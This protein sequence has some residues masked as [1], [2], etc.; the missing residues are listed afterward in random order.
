M[1]I[2]EIK[3][4]AMANPD[5]EYW[6]PVNVGFPNLAPWYM[7]SSHGNLKSVAWK[8]I[9]SNGRWMMIKPKVIKQLPNKYGYKTYLY[10]NGQV[11]KEYKRV[12]ETTH[13][14]VLLCFNPDAQNNLTVN[15]INHIKTDNRLHN[16]EWMSIGDNIRHSHINGRRKEE[17]E[18]RSFTPNLA[19]GENHYN[20]KYTEDDVKKV[21]ELT[22]TGKY[23]ANKISKLT[24]VS[25][26]EINHIRENLTW[27]HLP[28]AKPKIGKR[29]Y[30]YKYSIEQ[31]QQVKLLLQDKTL[32]LAEISRRTEVNRGTIAG[33]RD[34]VLW[35]DV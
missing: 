16:L 21:L 1:N 18:K 5:I 26:R 4:L 23:T 12:W 8:I 17:Y 32:S 19:K 35:K 30:P 34:G 22:Y 6:L 33:V 13:R 11:G 24:G 31:M 3:R 28:R 10:S 15:H 29:Y 25:V 14:V 2:E 7:I 20:A 9:K 27:K